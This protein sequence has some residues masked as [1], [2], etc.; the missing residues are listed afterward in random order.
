MN[1]LFLTAVALLLPMPSPIRRVQSPSWRTRTVPPGMFVIAVVGIATFLALTIG[2]VSVVIAGSIAFATLAYLYSKHREAKTREATEES[3]EYMLGHVVADLRSGTLPTQSFA[4]AAEELPDSTPSQVKNLLTRAG[5]HAARGGNGFET[6]L[7]HPSLES[8]A[9]VWALTHT[10]GLPA[11]ELFQ[12]SRD[13]LTATISHRGR[14]KASLTGPQATSYI[15]AALPL[16]GIVL[17]SSMG[18]D[19]IG[20]LGGGGIG[21]IMLI[22]GVSLICGGLIISQLIT[23]RASS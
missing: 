21:G 18:A 14:T 10:Y 9:R 22:T 5:E 8:V 20:L 3:L 19:P 16:A 6:L 4:R 23:E 11:A 15:L 12:H 2:R 17:G 13:H 7:H 1:V